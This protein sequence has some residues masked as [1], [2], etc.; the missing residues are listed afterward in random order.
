MKK[1]FTILYED[2]HLIACNKQAGILS[3]PDRYDETRKNLSHM[4]SAKYGKIFPVHRLDRHTSG[5]ILYCR[6]EDA[7]RKMSELFE[8]RKLVKKYIAIVHGIPY[9]EKGVIDKGIF[10]PAG[11]N[12]VSISDKGKP[13]VTNYHVLEAYRN[14]STLELELITGRRHQI[15]AHLAHIGNPVVADET[16][17]SEDAFYLSTIKKKKFNLKK[18]HEELPLI[19]R[20]MLHASHLSFEHPIDKKTI[21][22]DAPLSKDIRALQNQLKK[23]NAAIL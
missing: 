14:Y 1:N 12:K 15:R 16:Y 18:D 4:L 7:H 5:I 8:K 2:N 17:G 6:T 20:Q 19:S 10:I 22:I 23:W 13:S 9:E 11:K 21:S 3:I